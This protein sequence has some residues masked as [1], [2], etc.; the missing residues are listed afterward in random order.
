[1]C[2]ERGRPFAELII[3]DNLLV[4]AYGC[5]D[6]KTI[7]ENLENVYQL[8]PILKQMTNQLAGTVS[9]GERTMMAIGRSLM[10]G[11][12]LMLL[13]EPSTG[14]APRFKVETLFLYH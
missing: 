9:G 2:P 7:K 1:L 11:A 5:K 4:G 3:K 12:E 13:D 14:I 6:K 10:A 8:F